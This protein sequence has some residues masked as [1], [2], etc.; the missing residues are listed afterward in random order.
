MQ[1]AQQIASLVNLARAALLGTDGINRIAHHQERL[2]ARVGASCTPREPNDKWEPF[3]VDRFQ[4]VD[5]ARAARPARPRHDRRQLDE[6]R[7]RACGSASRSRATRTGCKVDPTRVGPM[8]TSTIVLWVSI[9]LLA[10]VLGSAGDRAADQPA[11]QGPV[12]RRQ[13]DPRRRVRLAPRRDDDDERDPPGQHGLQPDGARARQGRAGPRR[14]ARR[15]LARPAHAAR[16]PAPRGRDERAGRRGQGATW[17]WTSTSSTRSSTSSW[18]TRGRARSSSCRCDVA[19]IVAREAA[20]FRDTSQIRIQLEG[21]ARHA[22]ARRRRR[23]RP[24]AAE[25]VR[26]RAPL[27]PLDRDRHRR[28]SS[29]ATRAPGRG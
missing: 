6:R 7:R 9:A 13:P 12:V 19:T 1:A 8:S 16:A 28:A 23:A 10:T 2:D 26:E 17:R 15:H 18:T 5:R 11:A 14:H 25:P 21:R 27:R 29:S 4:R 20:A 22:R 24:R 3:E